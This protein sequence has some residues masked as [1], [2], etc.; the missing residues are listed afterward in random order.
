[1]MV[2]PVLFFTL[3]LSFDN[4][5][6]IDGDRYVILIAFILRL[7]IYTSFQYYLHLLTTVL[8][9]FEHFQKGIGASGYYDDDVYYY[10]SFPDHL[11]Y[12][13]IDYVPTDECNDLFDSPYIFEVSDWEMCAGPTDLAEPDEGICNGDSGG[14][15]YDEANNLLVGKG[16]V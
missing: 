15:L 13:D 1:M 7:H 4:R 2:I 10:Q 14:P 8:H 3:S 16:P 12:V 11:Q 5:L 9:L 6:S